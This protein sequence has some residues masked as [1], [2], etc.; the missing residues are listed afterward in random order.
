[1]SL[2]IFS[3]ANSYP[4]STY[5]LL[6]AELKKRG[7]KVRAI[8]KF[9]HDPRFPVTD[10]WPH[11]IEQLQELVAKEV[12]RHGGPAHL[13]GHSL[14]G[15]LS[16]ML[17]AQAPELAR[18]VLLVDA[19]ILAGWRAQTLGVIKATQ[20]V[21]R[22]SPSAVSHKRT[23]HW[24]SRDAA[25]AHFK[26]KRVFA[27]WEPEVLADYVAAFG[28]DE[29]GVT[30]AFDRKVESAIY[31]TL[32]D[33]LGALLKRQ[34]L[35]CPAA[36]I[37]GMAS[38]EMAQVGLAMTQEVTSGRMTFL[39]GGHLFPMEQPLATAAAIEANLRNME[40]LGGLIGR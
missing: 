28:E 35:R 32:P 30:L 29:S 33:N 7:F 12:G 27:R 14:G 8:D 11:L 17:A 39:D 1:M 23:H 26:A 20:L 4:A 19:P 2:L 25:L 36:F 21:K 31:N 9:G 6:F 5:K 18:S 38:E 13:V 40:R 10:N 16:L 3:H 24:V 37:G 15:F 22:F 34:P